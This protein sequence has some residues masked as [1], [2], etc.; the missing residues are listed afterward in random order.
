V[1]PSGSLTTQACNNTRGAAQSAEEAPSM[2]PGKPVERERYE[3][4]LEELREAT[5]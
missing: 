5:A 2:E 4:K 3:I 1:P